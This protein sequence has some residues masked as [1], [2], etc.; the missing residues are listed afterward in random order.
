MNNIELK[1][2]KEYIDKKNNP[3]G[4]SKADINSPAF[5]GIPTAPTATVGTNT[6]QIATTEFVQTAINNNN[7][8]VFYI[9][10][11][12]GSTWDS[13]TIIEVKE[14]T[15]Q[16]TYDIEDLSSFSEDFHSQA[17]SIPPICY[18][19]FDDYATL[20]TYN[21]SGT[22]FS[23]SCFDGSTNVSGFID[24]SNSETPYVFVSYNGGNN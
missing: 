10:I 3:S 6:T 16:Q 12:I 22:F 8:K 20:A 4:V 21:L 1:L 17:I 14:C 19:V 24:I 23:F 13:S 15:K 9:K 7:L 2:I 18:V 11:R 5:T